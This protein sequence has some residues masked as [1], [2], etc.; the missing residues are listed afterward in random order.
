MALFSNKTNKSGATSGGLLPVAAS[1]EAISSILAA[2]MKIVGEITFRGKARIDGSLEGN[3][4]G[5]HLI[6][7]ETGKIKGDLT[8][9]SL[10]CHGRINGNVSD[11]QVTVHS[12]AAIQGKLVAGSLTVE[13]GALLA[14][15][16]STADEGKKKP[17]AP[18]AVQAQAPEKKPHLA[19]ETAKKDS[20]PHGEQN[21][22]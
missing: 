21:R 6:L 17:T 4:T 19:A 3:C 5:E 8:L 22:K 2:E 9:E 20:A 15:E 1:S 13:P 14:G 12:S 11:R 7:S 10:V 18:A 16:I